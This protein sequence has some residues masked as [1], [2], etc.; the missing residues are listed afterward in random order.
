MLPDRW[1]EL[2]PLVDQLLDAPPEQRQALLDQL[3]GGDRERRGALETLVAECERTMPLLDR[4]AIERFDEFLGDEPAPVL[5]EVLG[6]RY[7]IERELGRGGMARV[8]LAQDLKHAR[9]VAVKVIRPELAA[10]LG[11]DRFLREIG[12]AARLRHPNIMPLFDSGDVDGLLYFVMPFEPGQ[13]LRARLARDGRLDIAD[14]VSILRDVARALAHAH[15]HGVV[16]RDV[17]PDNV[18]LSGDAAVVTDFGIAKA[19]LVAQ[20]ESAADR[21]TQVGVAIGT[22]EYMAPEQG[23]GDPN[24]DHRA[25]I[26]SF[27]CLAYETLTGKPPFT[28]TSSYQIVAAQMATPA[29]PVSATRADLRPALVAMVASCLEKDPAHRPQ[30]A[31]ELLAALGDT[32]SP[33]ATRPRRSRRYLVVAGLLALVLAAAL[34]AWFVRPKG[35]PVSLTVLPLLSRGGD[36]TQA[37]IA[38]GFGEDLAAALGRVPWIRVVSRIG[39]AAYRGQESIDPRATGKAL[40]AEYLVLGSLRTINGRQSLLIQ[41]LGAR[42]DSQLWSDQFD[43]PGDLAALRDQIAATIGDS[44][45]A[46]A[47]LAAKGIAAAAPR[48][49]RGSADAYNLYLIGKQKLNQRGAGVGASIGIFRDAIVLDTLAADAW[50]GLSLALEL[51]PYFR[52][53]PAGSVAVEATRAAR[54]ALALDSTLAEPH[55]ALGMVLAHRWQWHDAEAELRAAVALNP[56][57]VEAHTQLGRYLLAVARVPEANEELRLA[58][59]DDPASAVVA[60]LRADI[61]LNLDHV[62]SAARQS[63]RARRIDPLNLTTAIFSAMTLIR[64]GRLAEARRMA[65]AAPPYNPQ[66]MWILAAS[67]DS[68]AARARIAVLA[69]EN[70]PRWLG[71]TAIA[72]G[73]LG[74]GD[75]ARALDALEHA[76]AAGEFWP[77]IEPTKGHMF[78][79]IRTSPRFRALLTRVGLAGSPE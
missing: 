53:V 21:I 69:A 57:D 3:T 60:S 54:R 7:R 16:H 18:L 73:S 67:G 43:Q 26:Y 10:S 35:G 70:P 36:S 52:G 41:L 13:S 62:D 71:P 29:P 68:A 34:A 58:Q 20:T 38:E 63:E 37:L 78:D 64:E 8:Y 49:H 55:T 77:M 47:G 51:S 24:V 40:G 31:S 75:T 46:R 30:Q 1:A 28:G 2:A 17:K 39:S 74:L 44:L 45:R 65:S 61:W 72:F 9:E 12:I 79:P 25:D 11:R 33:A 15:A 42:D 5:P 76:T 27:G 14:A 32:S 50:S 66:V 6:G 4:P 22:P 59:A 23:L 56:R 19:V 48:A